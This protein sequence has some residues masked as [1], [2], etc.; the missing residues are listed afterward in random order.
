MNKKLLICMLPLALLAAC[1]APESD[2]GGTGS[3]GAAAPGNAPQQPSSPAADPGAEA[4]W[5]F[6]QPADDASLVI[7]PAA[8]DFCTAETQSVTVSWEVPK[9]YASPQVWVKVGSKPKLFSAPANR[10]S[11][12]ETGNWVTEAT[13]FYLIDASTGRVLTQA[14]P[15]AATCD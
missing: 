7:S 11:G 3:P 4:G 10:S 5:D 2:T 1:S 14:Q 6:S 9:A 13:T 12:E 8:V 15:T